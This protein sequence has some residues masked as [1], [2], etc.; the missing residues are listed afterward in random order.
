MDL[1]R[2]YSERARKAVA[3]EIREILKM[4]D[5]PE[6]ISFAGGIPNPETFPSSVISKIAAK[7]LAEDPAGTLQYGVTE[8]IAELRETL[9]GYM[10]GQGLDA[11]A[12]EIMITSGATQTIDLCSQAFLQQGRTALTESPTF[13]AALLSFKSHSAAIAD[14]KMDAEGILVDE[15][16]DRLGRSRMK[17]AEPTMLYVIPNFQNPTGVTLSEKR[18]KR[19]IEIAN[20]HDIIVLEDDPYG[21]LRYEG[22]AVRPVKAFDD[23]GRVVY[24]SSF[25]KILSPGMRVGWLVA[26]A[27]IVK[28]LSIMKQTADVHTG[29]LS[30]R[31]AEEYI[32]EGHLDRQL[33]E[34]IRLYGRKQKAMLAALD[35][36][37]PEEA[38]W[39]HPQGGMFLWATLPS[40]ID[41]L[42]LLPK[43]VERKVAYMQGRLFYP[44][45]GGESEMRL[46]FTHAS[47]DRIAEG[48]KRL[49]SLIDGELRKH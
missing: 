44:N 39:T 22:E 16:A 37:F 23:E 46:N 3:S 2:L 36:F 48:V 47:D 18:R 35:E 27:D 9:A 7:A 42:K 15:L 19:L 1:D 4:L 6:M 49:G 8:G 13:L 24:A 21:R 10:K 31:I 28:K 26:R 11:G 5:D 43:A 20:E 29:V 33:P 32:R 40:R 25:S 34:T 14:I 17:G 38:K 30:Q 12:E 45:G 41:T